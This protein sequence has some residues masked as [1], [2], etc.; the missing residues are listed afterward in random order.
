[1]GRMPKTSKQVGSGSEWRNPSR[2]PQG[3]PK[4]A[5]TNSIKS[6]IFRLEVVQNGKHKA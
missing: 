4:K 5:V 3:P 1:L 6:S 2:R